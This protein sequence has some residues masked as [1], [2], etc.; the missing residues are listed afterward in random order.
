MRSG[1]PKIIGTPL[2]DP[3]RSMRMNDYRK[4]SV[5]SENQKRRVFQAISNKG[6]KHILILAGFVP[7]GV[8]I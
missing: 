4:T 6:S 1:V 2:I 3:A 8:A 5:R 7:T